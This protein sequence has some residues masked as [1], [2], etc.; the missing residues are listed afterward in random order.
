MLLARTAMRCR[1]DHGCLS[2]TGWKNSIDWL[3]LANTIILRQLFR[4]KLRQLFRDKRE[5]MYTVL[6]IDLKRSVV[7]DL[8]V[9][10]CD[11]LC[12]PR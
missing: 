11:Q 12:A 8:K 2:L 3:C 9:L 10:T 1:L 4:D 6:L 5:H 7:L